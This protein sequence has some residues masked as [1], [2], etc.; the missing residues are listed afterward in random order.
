MI[1][2]YLKDRV[3]VKPI[4]TE[5]MEDIE[6]ED[7]TFLYVQLQNAATRGLLYKQYPEQIDNLEMRYINT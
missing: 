7:L 4:R 2:I 6:A 3:H 5:G 1:K